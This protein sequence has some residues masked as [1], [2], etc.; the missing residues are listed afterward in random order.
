LTFYSWK[1]EV[2]IPGPKR[3]VHPAGVKKT[4]WV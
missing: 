1:S 2:H 4:K 3:K